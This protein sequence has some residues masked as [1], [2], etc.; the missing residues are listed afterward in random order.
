MKPV[1]TIAAC[2][3]VAVG[4]VAAIAEAKPAPTVGLRHTSLGEVLVSASGRTLYEFSKD[5]TNKDTCTATAGCTET[6]PPLRAS[7]KPTAGA[8]VRGSLL[9]TITLSGGAKQ[10]TYAG[11]PLYLYSGDSG[12]GETSY[13]G[14]RQFGG[15]W[16][17]LNASGRAVK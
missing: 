2:A 1:H 17:A 14:A 8:G 3:L 16:D 12:P 6:W 5:H 13:V 10:V 11:H 4:S 15:S 9:S 7:G